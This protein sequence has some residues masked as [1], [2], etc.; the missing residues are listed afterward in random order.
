MEQQLDS[1]GKQ[2]ELEQY[3]RT[4]GNDGPPPKVL[5]PQVSMQ[6]EEALLDEIRNLQSVKDFERSEYTQQI[7]AIRLTQEQQM[8]ENQALMQK[9]VK[10]LDKN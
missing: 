8:L 1:T 2:S 4:M 6:A 9:Y 7:Q 5:P 3:L 10:I